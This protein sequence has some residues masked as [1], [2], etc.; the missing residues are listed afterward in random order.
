MA[1]KIRIK[2]PH[3][4][5]SLTV[6]VTM[7]GRSGKCPACKSSVSIKSPGTKRTQKPQS[8]PPPPKPKAQTHQQPV[9]TIEAKLAQQPTHGAEFSHDGRRM[10]AAVSA[11]P[12]KYAVV[13]PYLM[14]YEKPVAIAVQRQFPF[15]IFSDVVLLSTHRLLVFKRFF[16]KIDMFDVNY[17]DFNDVTIKQGFFTSAL[18]ITTDNHRACSVVRLISDQALNVYR[19]CQDIETKARMSRRQFQLEENRSRT[20]TMQVN[21]LVAGPDSR[22][23][24]QNPPS[25]PLLPNHDISNVGDEESDPYR[26]GE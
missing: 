13:E 26:L 10:L 16:T 23:A 5:K 6:P 24:P 21:N 3:C 8:P 19:L 25:Q 4:G 12:D 14:D 2:C 11:A 18:T 1:D 15:S 7:I 22:A 9:E 20:T 17:V